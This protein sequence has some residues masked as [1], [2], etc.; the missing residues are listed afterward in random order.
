M[1]GKLDEGDDAALGDWNMRICRFNDD[2][3]GVV[4]PFTEFI[5]PLSVTREPVLLPVEKRVPEPVAEYSHTDGSAVIGGYVYR[6]ALLPAL[7]SKY[8]FGDL[9]LSSSGLWVHATMS[10]L[11]AAMIG[12]L[13]FFMLVTNRPYWGANGIGPESYELVFRDLMQHPADR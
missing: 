4:R 2:R 10:S 5:K 13:V 7:S 3:I 1:A 8:V 6:G 11:L 12:L 9:A